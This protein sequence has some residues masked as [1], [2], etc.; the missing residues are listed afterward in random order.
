MDLETLIS[1]T[2][3]LSWDDPSPSLASLP[4][5]TAIDNTLALVGFSIAQKHQ[6]LKIV[7]EALNKAWSFA[8]PFSIQVHARNKYLFVFK[9]PN[10]IRK[11]LSQVTWN[12]NGSLLIL[13]KWSP[14]LSLDEINFH[15]APF[16]IQVHGLPLK[17][18]IRQNAFAIGKGIGNFLKADNDEA[19]GFIYRSYLRLLVEVDVRKPLKPGFFQNRH[20]AP[21]LWVNF[22]Y[23]RLGDYCADC[24]CLGH[25]SSS[26]SVPVDHVLS[27][28][29]QVS[30][31]D[32]SSNFWDRSSSKK[33]EEHEENS[34]S[35]S[36]ESAPSGESTHTQLTCSE[37]NPTRTVPLSCACEGNVLS[38]PPTQPQYFS[39]YLS[40]HKNPIVN[41][42]HA[43]PSN[44]P[45]PFTDQP[46]LTTLNLS[47]TITPPPEGALNVHPLLHT[48]P[49]ACPYPHIILNQA[50][51]NT[52]QFSLL[53]PW[54]NLVTQTD[55]LPSSP[56]SP[57]NRPS[58]EW[59]SKPISTPLEQAHSHEA[60][61]VNPSPV[62]AIP[63]LKCSPSPCKTL[64]SPKKGRFHPYPPRPP[65]KSILKS[66]PLPSPPTQPIEDDSILPLS[67]KR[68]RFVENLPVAKRGPA[69]ANL[70]IEE[71]KDGSPPLPPR[72]LSRAH[73]I[74]SQDDVS[75]QENSLSIEAGQAMPPTVP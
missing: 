74:S 70:N 30:L 24:G 57:H 65:N 67:R 15:T 31:K 42:F 5:E 66:S 64:S 49:Q 52:A 47:P 44:Q 19:A 40:F 1:Q 53:K 11:I 7:R 68:A 38:S 16:W 3:A 71:V 6:T 20:D 14:D 43:S 27:A 18:M 37:S 33:K 54:P 59:T 12:I 8:I 36:T 25:K 41:I 63:P 51:F 29:Y 21:P 28:Q 26:C 50:L 32:I 22:I 55:F 34:S 35:H 45:P 69:I 73:L 17:Y 9:H 62:H 75:G 10:H 13:K 60:S 56:P 58:L 23:E 46:S 2:S 48:T 4:P 39:Q 61:M 72:N